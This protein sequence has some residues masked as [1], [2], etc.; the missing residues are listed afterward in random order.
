MQ[1]IKLHNP[2]KFSLKILKEENVLTDYLNWDTIQSFDEFK[3]THK[4]NFSSNDFCLLADENIFDLLKK[5]GI[6]SIFDFKSFGWFDKKV[7]HAK[8]TTFD[9]EGLAS[10]QLEEKNSSF[11]QFRM[12]VR[13]A[14]IIDSIKGGLILSSRY[15]YEEFESFLTKLDY[16]TKSSTVRERWYVDLSELTQKEL[17]V[18]NQ[19]LFLSNFKDSTN[20]GNSIFKKT[21]DLIE[22][23]LD[24]EKDEM[25]DNF[26]CFNELTE[27]TLEYLNDKPNFNKNEFLDYLIEKKNLISSTQF[28]N[29]LEYLYKEVAEQVNTGKITYKP[30]KSLKIILSVCDSEIEDVKDEIK[31]FRGVE[32]FLLGIIRKGSNI[33]SYF[34]SNGIV[35]SI[36]QVLSHYVLDIQPRAEQKNI[37]KITLDS[38]A[39]KRNPALFYDKIHIGL[40]LITSF[41]KTASEISDYS[42]KVKETLDKINKLKLEEKSINVELTARETQVKNYEKEIKFLDQ[43]LQKLS[44]EIKDKKRKV[45][46]N[47]EEINKEDDKDSKK[48]IDKQSAKKVLKNKKEKDSKNLNQGKIPFDDETVDVY[49]DPDTSNEMIKVKKE[50]LDEFLKKYSK[51]RPVTKE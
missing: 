6:V 50:Q 45:S 13:S 3:S 49:V 31:D 28:Q 44:T 20:V 19:L 2:E 24:H 1:I 4:I 36:Y 12:T 47:E 51:S 43:H 23:F 8:W 18:C 46:K 32:L 39:I 35:M 26:R 48:A 5:K 16:Q 38:E 9:L 40:I 33:E 41:N 42:I 10:T 29:Q 7:N 22:D 27:L 15:H 14:N 37:L 11:N 30:I 17:Q 21:R 25:K 34:E